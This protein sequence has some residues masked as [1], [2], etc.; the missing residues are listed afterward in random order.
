M[1]KEEIIKVISSEGNKKGGIL[2]AGTEKKSSALVIVNE[3][4]PN[5]EGSDAEGEWVEL[6]N[7]SQEKINL[8]DWQ[9]DDGEAGSKPYRFDSDLW[10]EPGSFYAVDR[11]D[12]GLALN[13]SNESVRLF[14]NLVELIDEVYYEKS[15]E[16]ESYARGENNKFFWT[17]V[18]T[19]G[20]ENIISVAGSKEADIGLEN[21]FLVSTKEQKQIIE[22]TLEKI[23]ELESGELVKVNGVVAVE[24]GI[25]GAQYFYIVG[26]PGVQVYN[27]NKEFP[28]LK[29]GDY[30]EVSGEISISNGE[31]RIKTK[32]KED[33]KIIEHRSDPIPEELAVEK[34]TDD[35]LGN[36]VFVTG[37]ITDK[38][39]STIYLDDGTEEIRV[40]IKE[41][42]GINSAEIKEG[43]TLAIAGLVSRTESGLRIMP[44]SAEDIIKKDSESQGSPGQVLGEVAESDEW[45]VAARDK[46][47]QLF[48]YL[49]V[50][51]GGVIVVL[52]GLLIKELRKNEDK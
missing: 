15:F 16:G 14:D 25:L 10:L 34:I 19:P 5:P 33:M 44:R 46:K 22:T 31:K 4:L 40:Y 26:S 37:E 36:L 11:A 12:S 52:G 35:Y 47:L 2:L 3:I 1:E 30:I 51:A 48:R 43:E 9:L 13:N 7:I 38:K 41:A 23:K 50:L 6:K 20:E 17:T 45:S 42:T 27:Y 39:G 24:P 28:S 29:I 8:L 32:E 18:L 21:S 49:L